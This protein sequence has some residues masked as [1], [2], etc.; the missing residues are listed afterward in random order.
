MKLYE[1][2]KHIRDNSDPQKDQKEAV[3]ANARLLDALYRLSFTADGLQ[4][5]EVDELV[6]SLQRKENEV[7]VLLGRITHVFKKGFS[8][9]EFSNTKPQ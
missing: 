2:V 3:E 6:N 1:S 9:S 8:I 7:K 5:S 4:A